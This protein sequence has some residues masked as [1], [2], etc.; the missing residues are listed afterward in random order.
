MQLGNKTQ[1][2]VT[3]TEGGDKPTKASTLSRMVRERLHALLDG[4]D[5]TVRHL[6]E[7]PP[8]KDDPAFAA[9]LRDAHM[10]GQDTGR[11]IGAD[12]WNKATDYANAMVLAGNQKDGE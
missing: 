8:T 3:I 9:A 11:Q 10:A 6:P 2:F 4:A 1:L 7:P 5:I 12:R